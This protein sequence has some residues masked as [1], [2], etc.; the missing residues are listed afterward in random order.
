MAF[1][2]V[3]F[4]K[5]YDCFYKQTNGLKNPV[6]IQTLGKTSYFDVWCFA[7]ILLLRSRTG[8]EFICDGVFWRAVSKRMKDLSE[9][10]R[11]RAVNYELPRWEET[12]NTVWAPNIPAI[13]KFFLKR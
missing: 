6:R 5:V 8:K 7:G 3:S 1:K 13:Y 9:A 4:K 12:P 10:E 2:T 11:W